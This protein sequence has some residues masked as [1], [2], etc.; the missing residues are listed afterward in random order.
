MHPTKAPGIDGMHATFNQHF[1]PVVGDC[2]VDFIRQWWEGNASLEDI[3][4][5]EVTLILKVQSPKFIKDFRPIKMLNDIWRLIW[6]LKTLPKVKDFAWRMCSGVLPVMNVLFNRHVVQS[7]MCSRC[8]LENKD[9]WH[10]LVV[11]PESDLAW[12]GSHLQIWGQSMHAH[13]NSI[14]V[15]LLQLKS[16]LGIKVVKEFLCRCWVSWAWR[17]KSMFEEGFTNGEVL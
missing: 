10:C 9:I 4:T 16:A 17:N 1:W 2:I 13:F 14:L 15:C 11:C 6:S 12:E 8:G 5:T 7:P 3:N